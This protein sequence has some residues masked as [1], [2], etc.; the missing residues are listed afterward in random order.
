MKPDHIAA[1]LMYFLTL[2]EPLD[3]N[4]LVTRNF[5]LHIIMYVIPGTSELSVSCKYHYEKNNDEDIF[6]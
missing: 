4:F 6:K 3:Y 1:F 5:W 2:L